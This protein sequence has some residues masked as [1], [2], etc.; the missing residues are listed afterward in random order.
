M[1][2][3]YLSNRQ[4]IDEEAWVLKHEKLIFSAKPNL[5]F[6]IPELQTIVQSIHNENKEEIRYTM[7]HGLIKL[8]KQLTVLRNTKLNIL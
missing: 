7:Y 5:K 1:D 2:F 8:I 6:I 3:L 4:L